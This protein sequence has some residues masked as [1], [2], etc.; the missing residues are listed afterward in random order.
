MF[1]SLLKETVATLYSLFLPYAP[2]AMLV[3]FAFVAWKLWRHY[4]LARFVSKLEWVTLEIRLP[5]EISKTPQAMELVLSAMHQTYEGNA[6]DRILTNFKRAWFSLEIVSDGG[7]IHFYVHTQKFFRDIVEAAFY[8]H[9][10]GIEIGEVRDYTLDVPYDM[11]GGEPWQLNGFEY[12]LSRED[13]IPIKTYVD[14][15][16]E[17][18]GVK[19]E[20]K[21]DPM[22]Q[23][24]ELMGSIN[25]EE[26]IWLQFVIT[27]AKDESWKEEGRGIVNDILKREAKTKG[28]A[29]LSEGGFPI[30]PSLTQVEKEVVEAIERSL[31]QLGFVTGARVLYLAKE[32]HYRIPTLVGLIGLL[33]HYGSQNLNSFKIGRDIG[34]SFVWEDPFKW[35]EERQRREFFEGYVKRSFFYP[36]IARANT[37]I[38]TDQELATVFHLPGSVAQTPTLARIES[39]RGEA[40]VNLPV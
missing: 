34:Y 30:L 6:L 20:F 25:P 39:K 11:P 12:K 40:P 38:L 14:F 10:P 24:L 22:N 35:R 29:Q 5:R 15:R 27:A 4:T 9:Y 7:T 18:E 21:I 19:E 13:A 26:K 8:A 2:F 28:P 36:P 31:G 17:K 1:L 32:G 3:V 23:V 33:R 16:M 37:F